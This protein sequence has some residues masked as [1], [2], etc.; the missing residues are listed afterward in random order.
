M[1]ETHIFLQQN[2]DYRIA[3]RGPEPLV[4]NGPE[5]RPESYNA[6]M[7]LLRHQIPTPRQSE[8]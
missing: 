8:L 7:T 2:T 6:E 4:V 5:A 3:L 1:L